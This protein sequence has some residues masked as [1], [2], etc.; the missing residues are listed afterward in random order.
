VGLS[1]LAG[2]GEFVPAADGVLEDVDPDG[3]MVTSAQF[4]KSSGIPYVF[5]CR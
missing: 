4:Q 5:E 1:L 2:D 3:K